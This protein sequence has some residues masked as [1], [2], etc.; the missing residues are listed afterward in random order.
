MTT[1]ARRAAVALLAALAVGCSPVATTTTT[2]ADSEASAE[3]PETDAIAA[4]QSSDEAL[5]WG[6]Y[7]DILTH[8]AA[9]AAS[10]LSAFTVGEY[11]EHISVFADEQRE[12]VSRLREADCGRFI[13]D[14][15]GWLDTVEQGLRE[16]DRM[17]REGDDLA[18]CGEF[19]DDHVA[20][21]E[22]GPLAFDQ[23]PGATRA[24]IAEQRVILD[25][26]IEADCERI[27][28]FDLPEMDRNL[29]EMEAIVS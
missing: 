9:G 26:L 25:R 7:D 1:G 27:V 14:L 18:L 21:F 13:P 3:Q 28:G 23:G 8:A 11:S 5:C 12:Y 10:D 2:D 29:R 22:T 17:E 19:W 20:H 16:F 24:W 4:D 6:L 15:P